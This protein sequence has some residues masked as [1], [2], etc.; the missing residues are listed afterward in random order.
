MRDR[1]PTHP[2]RVRLVP[3]AG[4]DNLYDI[5]RADDAIIEGMPLCKATL[6]PDSVCDALGIDREESTPADALLTICQL[7][8]I[9]KCDVLIQIKD[10][11]G[12]PI[13]ASGAKVR[14]FG[15][16]RQ[17]DANGTIYISNF[18]ASDITVSADSPWIDA[19]IADFVAPLA[20]GTTNYVD[21]MPTAKEQ[22]TAD[23]L[24]TQ[25]VVFSSLVESVDIFCVGGGAGGGKSTLSDIFAGYGGG[26]GHTTT[27]LG[28]GV[29][30]KTKYQA[31]VGAGGASATAGGATS[32]LGVAA[33]GGHGSVG[34][35][36][37]ASSTYK[38]TTSSAGD[39]GTNGGYG[40]GGDRDGGASGQGTTTRAFGVGS[41]LLCG[42]GGGRGEKNASGYSKGGGGLGGGGGGGYRGENGHDGKDGLGGGG[43][44][45][46]LAGSA[47]CTGGRGGSGRII[48][49]WTNK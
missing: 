12:I 42:G 10:A 40:N 26:G 19:D 34:G 24:S 15:P 6:L 9:G 49:R 20:G 35:S 21:L 16:E 45:A 1:V 38:S 22:K 13:K 30:P 48:V 4:Q 36:G 23:I 25:N 17:T 39:G 33:E 47:D 44:G 11:D 37:G 31:I 43:G 41:G 2:G 14:G 28:L 5:T 7:A 27:K 3:V 18:P 29:V 46:G 8:R 32:L